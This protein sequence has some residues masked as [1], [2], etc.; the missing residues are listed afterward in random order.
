[1]TRSSPDLP[2]TAART[3]TEDSSKYQ[4]STQVGHLLR[5]AYQRHTALFQQFIPDSKLTVAQFVVMCALNE[6]GPT[7]IAN[8]V[9]ATVIDQATIRGVVD[10]LKNREL[11]SLQADPADR[12]KVMVALTADGQQLVIEMQPFARAITEETFGPLNEAERVALLY[13]LRKMTDA[14]AG[15][16]YPDLDQMGS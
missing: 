7:S 9:K 2:Q 3:A 1:M 12:R 10:R 6:D 13:L 11:V 8:L 15:T 14:E 16:K 5:R 4:F